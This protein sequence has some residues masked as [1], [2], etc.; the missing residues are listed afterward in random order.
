MTTVGFDEPLYILPFDHYREFVDTF[1]DH[2][3]AA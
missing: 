3:R 2:A 1:E